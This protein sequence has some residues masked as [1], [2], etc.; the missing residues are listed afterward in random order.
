MTTATKQSQVGWSLWFQWVIASV[1]GLFVGHAIR[2]IASAAIY[3]AV[4]T[5][6][7]SRL[8]P[9]FVLVGIVGLG[10]LWAIVGLA[11]LIVLRTRLSEP[12]WWVL[13]SGSG[14]IIGGT[15]AYVA[16][17]FDAHFLGGIAIFGALGTAQWLVLRKQFSRAGWWVLAS[18]AGSLLFEFSSDSLLVAYGIYGLVTGGVL[19]WLLK[20]TAP[21]DSDSFEIAE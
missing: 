12:A 18:V 2:V 3:T 11:Q 5:I 15:I 10:I 4:P 6:E 16:S 20:Q 8:D 21:T 14:A 19:L 17:R 13:A 7:N 9:G 1:A